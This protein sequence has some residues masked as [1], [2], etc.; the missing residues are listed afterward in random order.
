MNNFEEAFNS[1]KPFFDRIWEERKLREQKEKE[2][3]ENL[4]KAK[5]RIALISLNISRRTNGGS[6]YSYRSILS[7]NKLK[8]ADTEKS[9]ERFLTLTS[10]QNQ[11]KK[12]NLELGFPSQLNS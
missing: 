3:K 4:E 8:D 7:R 2:K 12:F 6:K 10:S 1:R 9:S 5:R 11:R